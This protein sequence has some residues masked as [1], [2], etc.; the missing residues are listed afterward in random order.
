MKAFA[1]WIKAFPENEK[2]EKDYFRKNTILQF[3][4]S[5]D[6]I[7]AAIL[8]NPGSAFPTDEAINCETKLKLQEISKTVEGN[9]EWRVFGVDS[10][11]RFLEKIF[12]GWYLGHSKKLD[13]IILLYNLFNI[14][15]AN[16]EEALRLRSNL[17]FKGSEDDMD[18]KPEELTS[19]NVPIYI[20][21]GQIGKTVLAKNAQ[22][23]FNAISNN[24]YYYIGEDFQKA[25][26]YHPMYVNTSYRKEATR[27]WLCSFLGID[28]SG[29][30]P[31]ISV[32]HTDGIEIINN[33]KDRIEPSKIVDDKKGK[34][35]FRVCNDYLIVAIVS[36]CSKQLVQWQHARYNKSR[37]YVSYLPDYE[38]TP[39]IR[40]IL[41][42]HD[43]DINTRST[44][45]EKSLK[46]FPAAT[47]EEISNLIWNEIQEITDEI[48]FFS[49]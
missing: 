22:K 11:M 1:R 34:L 8:I 41:E 19:L 12:S 25:R 14:R 47:I 48:N 36:Q 26:C 37:D 43:Y 30:C 31:L 29:V 4:K 33:L 17:Q 13:G 45:G 40:E 3:G 46:D 15:C 42:S 6:V 35:S 9:G 32:N 24:V 38:Y 5:W 10:T 2:E 16:L 21:W 28:E 39:D 27:K 23:I 44:L 18:T 20:G 7:G 49:E